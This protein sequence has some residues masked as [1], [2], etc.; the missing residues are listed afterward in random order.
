VTVL[1]LYHTLSARW[2][3]VADAPT[4]APLLLKAQLLE[5]YGKFTMFQLGVNYDLFASE[6]IEEDELVDV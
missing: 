5:A 4:M 2:I 6:A 3:P 1:Y